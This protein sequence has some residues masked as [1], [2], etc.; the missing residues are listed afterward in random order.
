MNNVAL[1]PAAPQAVARWR[2]HALPMLLG[3]WVLGVAWQVV[4]PRL[5]GGWVQAGMVV[6]AL[7]LLVWVRRWPRGWRACTALALVTAL[8]GFAST[9]W[10]ASQRLAQRLAPALEG[11]D[12]LLT[13]T[14]ASMPQR[15]AGNAGQGWRFELAVEAATLD[16]QPVAVPPRVLLSW[17]PARRSAADAPAAALPTPHAG[18]RWQLTARLR[19]PHGARNPHGFDYELRLWEQ[20]LGATGSVRSNPRYPSPQRLAAAGWSLAGWRQA[21]RERILRQPVAD[22]TWAGAGQRLTGVVAALVTG[23]Q[24]AIDRADWAVFRATGTAHL[25]SISGLHITLF[26]WLAAAVLGALWRAAALWPPTAGWPRRWPA[27]QVGLLGGVALAAGY[28][29]FAGWG[30]PAQRTVLMLACLAALRLAGL[31]WP[32]WL[33]GLLA[34]ALVL[35]LD[36]WA[37]LQ[38][39][40]WLSFV[41]VMVLF[42]NAVRGPDQ[43]PRHLRQRALALLKEQGMLTL[44]LTPLTLLLFGQA[45]VVGVVA[46]LLAI[47]LVTLLVTPLA[48]LGLLWPALWQ[49]AAWA[50]APLA[51]VLQTLA[52]W[53]WASISLPVA[54]WPLGLAAVAGGLWLAMRWPLALRLQGL[55]LVLLPLL[56]QPARPPHGHFAL[57][58][59]DVGQGSAV[60]VRTAGHALLYDTGPRY[61]PGSDAGSRVIAPLLRQLGV[62]LNAVVLSHDDADHTGGAA[63]VL[64]AQPQARVHAPRPLPHLGAAAQAPALCQAG[65]H[66]QWDG[67][68]FEWLHPLP[69]AALAANDNAQ[70]CVLRVSQTGPAGA[71]ALLTGDIGAAQEAQLQA[72][73]PALLRADVLLVPHHGSAQSSSPAFVQ[74]VGARWAFVQAGRGN[75]F[76]HPAPQVLARYQ[77]VGVPIHNTAYCGAVHWHSQQP[78]KAL[79]ERIATL[80]YWQ[81]R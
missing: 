77:A 18:E 21:V 9:D 47:P 17:W 38:A 12:V 53:P 31:R 57:L 26:A 62:R 50:L 22:T 16:G 41:A 55:P 76:G 29:L 49:A 67:V 52:A 1:G 19:Q 11:R 74:A 68:R 42:A 15:S 36:P 33:N 54:P 6:V 46:N 81:T 69:G 32:W 63:S 8:A 66:W 27:A 73:A 80:R 45:S 35:A 75:A 48:L 14:V 4:Q 24:A 43:G 71:A 34:A 3:G 23:D 58:V 7:G 39:G 79:C 56:W 2:G 44:A 37:V 59:L 5:Q 30:V 25:M 61:S 72:H 65:Q 70:S 64:A 78:E 20:N 60:L 51:A 28:A 40:F 10:R 13:G